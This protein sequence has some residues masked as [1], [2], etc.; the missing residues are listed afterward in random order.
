[1]GI[2][3]LTTDT[4]P[5]KATKLAVDIDRANEIAIENSKTKTDRV[6]A[7]VAILKGFGDI[8][9]NSRSNNPGKLFSKPN[10]RLNPKKMKIILS[11]LDRVA[12]SF[13]K[14]RDLKNT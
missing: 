3:L 6:T 2:D 11:I 5:I 4:R 10:T 13:L 12:T 8:I 7:V 14:K 9:N 1:L